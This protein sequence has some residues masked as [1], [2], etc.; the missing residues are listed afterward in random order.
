MGNYYCRNFI[1]QISSVLME[2]RLVRYF[3]DRRYEYKLLF[4]DLL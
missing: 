3:F 2:D 4:K 1:S